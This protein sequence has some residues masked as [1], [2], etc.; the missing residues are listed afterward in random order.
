MAS[1]GATGA[2]TQINN[3]VATTNKAGALDTAVS[4]SN[5]IADAAI[6]RAASR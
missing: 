6:V 5:A 1:R 3:K 4:R 2:Q